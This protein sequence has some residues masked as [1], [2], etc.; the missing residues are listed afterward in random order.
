ML[1]RERQLRVQDRGCLGDW[2]RQRCSEICSSCRRHFWLP[3]REG[4]RDWSCVHVCHWRARGRQSERLE[5]ASCA[6]QE[7]PHQRVRHVCGWASCRV[8]LRQQQ[9]RDLSHAENKLT[10]ERTYFKL[11]NRVWELEVNI[12]P[13]TETEDILTKM[14]EQNVDELCPFEEQV[15]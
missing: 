2:H 4:Q 12:I 3:R 5:R 10:V 14:Q 11:R 13:K 15:L 7:E 9:E 8:R 6:S 1:S